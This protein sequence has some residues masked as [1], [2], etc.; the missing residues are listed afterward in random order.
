MC[1]S[2]PAVNSGDVEGS[3]PD[4]GPV[5]TWSEAEQLWACAGSPTTLPGGSEVEGAEL[6]SGSP[7]L[8]CL[9]PTVDLK[10]P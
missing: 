10:D 9:L 6:S 5:L 1:S 3:S 7:G 4:R 8:A 2:C